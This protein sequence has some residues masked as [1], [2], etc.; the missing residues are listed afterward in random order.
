MNVIIV[1]G[2]VHLK[3]VKI[4]NFVMYNLTQKKVP[5]IFLDHLERLP[6]KKTMYSFSRSRVCS[7]QQRPC[8]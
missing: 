2:S 1:M 4:A 5:P 6:F 3:M 8:W 7:P